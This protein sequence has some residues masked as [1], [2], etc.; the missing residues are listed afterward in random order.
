MT[1]QPLSNSGVVID[2]DAIH[3]EEVLIQRIKEDPAA[4]GELYELYVDRIYNYCYQR[5]GNRAD[6]EDLT[7]RTFHRAIAHIQKFT[8]RGIP[9]AIWLYRIAHNL[10][11]NWHRDRH[12]W[13]LVSLDAFPFTNQH[14]SLVSGELAE[15]GDLVEANE[16]TR[17]LHHLMRDLPDERQTL[18]ILK[19]SEG[20]S[21]AEIGELLGRSEGAVKSLYHRTLVSLREEM[22][23]R[24]F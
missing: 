6:A 22:R 20:W 10:V 12:R 4:F 13:H 9:V 23:K 24:G 7:A 1:Q 21:N 16:E 5:T 15:P 2:K 19:F 14:H 11:S 17:I 18:L 3:E 8:P